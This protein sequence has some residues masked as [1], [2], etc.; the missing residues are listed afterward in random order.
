MLLSRRS[1]LTYGSA[2]AALASA[3]LPAVARTAAVLRVSSGATQLVQHLVI[4]PDACDG[5]A[6]CAAFAL[7]APDAAW[8]TGGLLTDRGLRAAIFSNGAR[9]YGLRRVNAFQTNDGMRYAATWQLGAAAPSQQRH[10]LTL[11]Q[12]R[13]A[14]DRFAADGHTIS[15]LD[16]AATHAGVRFAALWEKS[17]APQQV[18]ADLTQAQYDAK[19]APLASE[20]FAP[21]QLTGYT[22]GGE[23]RFAALFD[24]SAVPRQAFASVYAA[25]FATHTR[26][27]RAEGYTLVDAAGYITRGQPHYTTVWQSA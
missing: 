3:P 4:H 18:F 27:M 26:A 16:A 10:G 12:F 21:R 23:T 13:A 25:H 11:A 19:L 1:A 24:K 17:A 6:Y 9:G 2:V 5:T 8:R 14:A 7:D 20:G 22:I 15:H